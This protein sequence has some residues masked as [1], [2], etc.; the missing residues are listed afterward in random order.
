VYIQVDGKTGPK[1]VVEPDTI[2]L[3]TVV[4]ENASHWLGYLIIQEGGS[5]RLS[6]PV[7]LDAAG[8]WGSA[9]GYYDEPDLGFGYELTVAGNP[10]GPVTAG[11]QFTFDYS[12]SGDL[13]DGTTISLFVDPH[14]EIPAD[15]VEIIPEPMTVALLGLGALFLRRR[16]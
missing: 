1:A 5:G 16:K 6:N 3:I 4:S 8:N 11:P 14:Y 2:A 9:G 15:S 12:Y 13:A 7:A 10:D